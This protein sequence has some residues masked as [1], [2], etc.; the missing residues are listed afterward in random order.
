MSMASVPERLMADALLTHTSM[1]PNFSTDCA[2][3]C[4]TDA[5]ARMSPTIGS[6]EPPAASIASAAVYTV[7]SS[8]GCGSAVLAI[9]ATFAP[10]AAA[11][12]A[13][14][15]PMPREPPEMNSV[16][17][18]SV[19]AADASAV[20]LGRGAVEAVGQAGRGERLGD[21]LHLGHPAPAL[22]FASSACGGE[23]ALQLG[24]L[25]VERVR[26]A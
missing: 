17:P 3:A 10:S 25:A 11:R 15:R 20:D 21:L 26:D 18:S 23:P 8:L 19:I 24:P 9:S 5:S 22:A 13:I 7:P 16:L 1:P 14:A 12:R 2:T 4:A 6:A